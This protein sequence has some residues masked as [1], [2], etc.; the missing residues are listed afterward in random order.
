MNPRNYKRKRTGKRLG[1]RT[2]DINIY[3]DLLGCCSH[4]SREKEG[5][6]EGKRDGVGCFV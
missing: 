1:Y 2:I 3:V 4:R 6:R 5:E